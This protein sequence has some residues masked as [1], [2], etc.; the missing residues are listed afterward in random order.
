MRAFSHTPGWSLGPGEGGEPVGQ[1]HLGPVGGLWT[2]NQPVA[3]TVWKNTPLSREVSLQ[4][5]SL[6]KAQWSRQSQTPLP[7]HKPNVSNTGIAGQGSGGSGSIFF[8]LLLFPCIAL[9]SPNPVA[10]TTNSLRDQEA[11]LCPFCCCPQCQKTQPC[12]QHSALCLGMLHW[13][14]SVQLASCIALGVSTLTFIAGEATRI[15]LN[16][17]HMTRKNGVTLVWSLPTEPRA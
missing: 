4:P 7:S 10:S 13:A 6:R 1:F 9:S 16:S 11:Q 14:E 3:H 8:F 2:L 5:Y 17:D 15:T 12:G